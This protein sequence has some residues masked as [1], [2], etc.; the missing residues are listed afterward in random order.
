MSSNT[1]NDKI[2]VLFN[3]FTSKCKKGFVRVDGEEYCKFEVDL[4]AAR[5]KIV[6]DK[7]RISK[8][9]ESKVKF[10]IKGK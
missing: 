2:R 3:K 1:K 4:S 9:V 5:L 10:A 6:F 8:A 7:K